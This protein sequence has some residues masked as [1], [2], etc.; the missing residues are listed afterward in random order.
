MK[1]RIVSLATAVAVVAAMMAVSTGQAFA[2]QERGCEG[3]LRAFAKQQEPNPALNRQIIEQCPD[4]VII[5]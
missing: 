3:L 1:Q 2:A 5:S 4:I